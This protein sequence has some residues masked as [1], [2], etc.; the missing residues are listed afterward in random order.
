MPPSSAVAEVGV[1][2][3]PGRRPARSWR[4][5]RRARAAPAGPAWIPS[6]HSTPGVA[7]G[8][9][10]DLDHTGTP[11][12]CIA[13]PSSA[14]HP[15]ARRADVAEDHFGG[16]GDAEGAFDCDTS[17]QRTG[18]CQSTVGPRPAR[19]PSMAEDTEHDGSRLQAALGQDG[20]VGCGPP[21]RPRTTSDVRCHFRSE[22]RH[23]ATARPDAIA[24][25]ETPARSAG[26]P[27]AT[28]APAEAGATV[29]C[30]RSRDV[31]DECS[32]QC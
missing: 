18:T 9:P 12:V 4:P 21:S 29:H 23:G 6:G 2:G 27:G 30:T 28:V 3:S 7:E 22:S 24:G 31:P 16:G 15:R 5:P 11:P 32:D 1:H 19:R 26:S 14:R 8:V 17:S 13:G 10:V 25:R 20:R